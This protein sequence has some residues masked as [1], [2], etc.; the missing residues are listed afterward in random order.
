MS[1]KNSVEASIIR[2]FISGKSYSSIKK[3]LGCGYERIRNTIDYYH[4]FGVIPEEK[5]VGRPAHLTNQALTTIAAL[6][7][8]NRLAPCYVISQQLSQMGILGCSTSTVWRARKQLFFNYKPPK[9]K[10]NLSENQKMTRCEFA[11]SLLDSNFDFSRII[12]S[13]ES[14]FCL[15][16]DNKLRWIRRGD[17]TPNCFEETEKFNVSVMV[18]GAIGIGYKS[19]LVL[20]SDGVDNLEYRKII[21]ESNM[22]NVLDARYGQGNYTF[23]QDGAP[24]HKSIL[25]T[26][27]LKKRC[28]FI[29]C[30]PANSPDLNPIEHLWG[31]MKRIL[32][33]KD[34]KTKND[35]IKEVNDIW[36]SFPQSSIDSLVGSFYGRLRMV[37]G[38]EGES[39]SDILRSGIHSPPQF[40]LQMHEGKMD[41]TDMI[42]A[43]DPTVDDEPIDLKTQREWEVDEDIALLNGVKEYGKKWTIIAN[44]LHERTANSCRNRYNHIYKKK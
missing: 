12:F 22:F 29:N 20:C 6:T 25:T 24:A 8:Q 1:S 21:D 18:Y 40:P 37:L 38:V 33:T 15:T 34:I 9:H 41:L 23:M 4:R 10:Q 31:A 44:T 36:N 16:P 13:D 43:C 39:I 27:Y 7:I 28:S 11:Y 30:W 35:L 17:S 19:K 3:Y 26:L 5:K 14:R 42:T 32:K 2:L